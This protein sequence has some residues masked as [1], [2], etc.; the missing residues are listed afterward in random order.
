MI[1][2]RL[3]RSVLLAL[4]V[5]A[6][7]ATPG[8]AQWLN[9]QT[10]SV[11]HLAMISVD[12]GYVCGWAGL[13]KK[14][15]D[16]GVNWTYLETGTTSELNVIRFPHSTVGYAAGAGGT[17]IKTS[18]SGCLWTRQTVP[19]TAA[20][21]GLAFADS[22]TGWAVTNAGQIIKT[23]N[24]GLAWTIQY[25]PAST[26]F[27]AVS[28]A[29][30]LDAIATGANGKLFY[31]HDGGS[32]W[33]AGGTGSPDLYLAVK[34]VDANTIYLCADPQ[35][36]YKSTN[37]G[38][39]WTRI[40]NGFGYYTLDFQTASHGIV[41]G[42]EGRVLETTDGG[43]TWRGMN[44]NGLAN[45]NP[46]SLEYLDIQLIGSTG[47]LSARPGT[48]LRLERTSTS[49]WTPLSSGARFYHRKVRFA[50]DDVAYATGLGNFVTSVDAGKT[51]NHVSN[52]PSNYLTGISFWDNNNGL[53][54]GYYGTVLKT[55]NGT[56]WHIQMTGTTAHL[57]NV[58]TAGTNKAWAVADQGVIIHSAD[59]GVSWTQQPSGTTAHLFGIAFTD[60][61][62]GWVAG[63]RTILKTTNGGASWT[64]VHADP[65]AFYSSIRF[66][67][68]TTGWA[69]GN[70]ASGNGFVDKTI[71]GGVTWVRQ[72]E[73]TV[74]F[75]APLWVTSVGPDV[76]ACGGKGSIYHSADGGATWAQQ[77][78]GTTGYL[79][80]VVFADSQRGYC[81]GSDGIVVSTV[82]GGATWT[83]HVATGANIF[84]SLAARPTGVYWCGGSGQINF[85]ATDIQ[86][87]DA[88]VSQV[89][90]IK[91][92]DNTG[93]FH[94]VDA[95]NGW[96]ATPLSLNGSFLFR[97]F[98][99]G[100]SWKIISKTAAYGSDTIV[101]NMQFKTTQ[102]GYLTCAN[103]MFMSTTNGGKSWTG[104]RTPIG[105]E[106]LYNL[107]F[108]D[109]NEGFFVG[110]HGLMVRT[111]D[112][113]QNFT[114]AYHPSGDAFNK[115]KMTTR[116]HIWMASNTRLLY[117]PDHGFTW[118][119]K[120]PPGVSTIYDMAF[121]DDQTGW[122]LGNGNFS[123]ATTD[124]GNTWT[125]SLIFPGIFLDEVYYSLTVNR[126]QQGISLC[127]GMVSVLEGVSSSSVSA[128]FTV[129]T[130]DF[131][132]RRL[133]LTAKN[134]YPGAQ[135]SWLVGS[136]TYSGSPVDVTLPASPA[137]VQIRLSIL[138]QET[139]ACTSIVRVDT[140]YSGILFDSIP[141]PAFEAALLCQQR[142]VQFT[143]RSTVTDAFTTYRWSFGDG[144][145]SALESP[146]HAYPQSISYNATLV[147]VSKNGCASA[148]V[149]V[150]VMPKE[151]AIANAG[152]D[153]TVQP[154]DRFVLAG[155]C[156]PLYSWTPALPLDNPLSATPAGTL[157]DD[158]TFMLTVTAL[159]G[160]TATDGMNV[161]VNK[162]P[163]LYVPDA[164][165]PDGNGYNDLLH[166]FPIGLK[167]VDF[168]VFNRWGEL[169]FE[170]NDPARG[171][172][173]SVRGKKQGSNNFVWF[174]IGELADGTR[175]MEKGNVILIR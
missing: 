55:V 53:A 109:A 128:A 6:F 113:G 21:T 81:V 72:L 56:D 147:A 2:F 121:L 94:F 25:T 64:T 105:N 114:V 30:P 98:N 148:P 44:N 160:C 129:D 117:S 79:R 107:D 90:N 174:A 116:D 134:S 130:L 77:A 24:S 136:T 66:E 168:K 71:D 33:I 1:P 171:W 162:T 152:P 16:A 166:A 47:Y 70:A 13:V 36:V 40:L 14:T 99:G 80:Q 39:S 52:D 145:T 103:G 7:C 68:A 61:Q 127:E 18:N 41:A 146:S 15:V 163:R 31:T 23:T 48:L 142:Q 139:G 78:S 150:A 125:S 35:G 158:T 4:A 153:M 37:G 67:S 132:G 26:N 156:G 161:K 123:Y 83:P 89:Y 111:A 69:C 143:N 63:Y 91:S 92:L 29:G 62:T 122:V 108:F 58:V 120:T 97:T 119:T 11:Y 76:W 20:I 131:C 43:A 3:L 157:Q 95:D 27:S 73:T 34:M 151:P 9:T 154:G 149:V 170:T 159:N 12:T 57:E 115:V 45:N 59:G 144:G 118:Q 46:L 104:H 19:T 74:L 133:R 5:T 28:C 93:V 82:N 86:D 8:R 65:D 169:V 42:Y 88:W 102:I 32:S 126:R 60:E 173:G 85:T 140:T 106:A 110:Q 101:T 164:F 167:L 22:A 135:Y 172:N 50:T 175:I 17:I 49:D 165:T 38:A 141:V 84:T 138:Q 75:A 51:W 124:G 137:Q 100:R 54:A 87:E 96:L 10:N 155:C 112:G